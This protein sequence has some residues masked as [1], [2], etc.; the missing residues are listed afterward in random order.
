M[1]KTLKENKKLIP[2]VLLALFLFLPFSVFAQNVKLDK[3]VIEASQKETNSQF[4]YHPEVLIEGEIEGDVFILA[5]TAE[6]SGSIKGNI[7]FLGNELRFTRTS[8]VSGSLFALANEIN[9]SGNFKGNVYLGCSTLN[10]YETLKQEG[11]INFLANEATLKG[12]FLKNSKGKGIYVYI[13]KAIFEKDLILNTKSLTY[14]SD[15]EVKGTLRYKSPNK[16]LFLG[17]DSQTAKIQK[18]EWKQTKTQSF[19]KLWAKEISKSFI[20][21]LSLIILGFIFV[22]LWKEKYKTIIFSLEENLWPSLGWG[23]I[24]SIVLPPAILVLFISL[25]GIPLGLILISFTLFWAYFSYIIVGGLLGKHLVE[26]LGKDSEKRPYLSLALGIIVIW[27]IFS[28]PF[29]GTI[30]K[31][32]SII[33]GIGVMIKERKE[34]LGV[35]Y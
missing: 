31:I 35:N 3:F 28:L 10:T 27:I 9:L 7:Y 17:E 2:F 4:I 14:T 20:S 18:E 29:I 8:A 11:E 12:H 34:I 26:F 22:L 13:E 30:L 23:I 33:L 24:Y 6:I 15:T 5:K 19:W 16:A 21:I 25:I 1:L 32:L